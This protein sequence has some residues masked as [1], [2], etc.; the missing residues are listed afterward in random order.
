MQRSVS[1]VR[2]RGVDLDHGI[3]ALLM[4]VERRCDRTLEPF[5]QPKIARPTARGRFETIEV[6]A[7]AAQ[8]DRE[9]SPHQ[10]TP[11][12]TSPPWVGSIETVAASGSSPRRNHHSTTA[13]TASAPPPVASVM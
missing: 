2:D 3:R 1:T 6:G 5:A 11:A 10:N 9:Q 12:M 8:R 13:P 4:N 7:C